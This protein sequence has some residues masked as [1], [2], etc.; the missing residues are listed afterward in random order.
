MNKK[1]TK[2]TLRERLLQH[3]RISD[4]GCWEWPLGLGHNG[5][6][7]IC[8]KF[9]TLLVHRASYQEFIGPIPQGLLVCHRCD[10]PKCYNPMHLFLGTPKDNTM[11]MIRKGRGRHSR[12]EQRSH[13]TDDQI[14][15]I[16]KRYATGSTLTELSREFGCRTSNIHAIVNRRSWKHI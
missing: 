7:K 2:G 13:R 3:A 9:R 11:D 4:S 12:G 5:Y 15:E 8:Y 1:K 14:R 6:G 10:N 16:R